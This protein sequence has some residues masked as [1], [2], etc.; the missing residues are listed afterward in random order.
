MDSIV[1]ALGAGSGIDIRAL[2]TQ[3]ATASRAPREAALARRSER[4]EARIS[5]LAQMAATIDSFSA[6]LT[7]LATGGT[8]RAQASSSDPA[9]VVATARA[10]SSGSVA[11][12]STSIE[13]LN[14]ARAQ[15]LVSAN[16]ADSAAAVGEGVLAITT[17]SGTT[18]ITVDSNNNSLTG[19]AAAI[20]ASGSG[21]RARIVSDADGTR[22]ALTGSTGAAA[23][24]EIEIVSGSGSGIERLAYASGGGGAMTLSQ[25]AADAI[26][27]IDG[28]ELRRSTNRIDDAID[29]LSLDL[30]SATVGRTVALS[31][32][33]PT[34]ALGSAIGDFVTAFNE[35]KAQLD[36]LGSGE[37]AQLRGEPAL[38][39]LRKRLSA[40]STGQL[41]SRGDGPQ[42]LAEIGVRTNRDGTLSLD[43]VRLAA[44]LDS[45]AAA[46]A[47][48]FAPEAFTD[49]AAVRIASD[50]SR[51]RPG[52]YRLTNILAAASGNPASGFIDGLAMTAA[53]NNLVAPRSS[54]VAGL[55]LTVS[56]DVAE[57]TVTIDPGLA[58]SL[59]SISDALKSASGP[60]ATSQERLRREAKAIADEEE[61]LG[62]TAARYE[63]QLLKTFAAMDSRVAGLRATQSYLTQQIAIWNNKDA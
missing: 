62:R 60:L 54:S 24:F 37:S 39:D 20:N 38:V 15:S 13:V 57:A 11:T 48:F 35:V 19:V 29:G 33:L 53:G 16:F 1:T 18:Q 50:T 10:S 9:A 26:I 22:L 44:A 12:S 59:R 61:K 4:N 45:N 30:R 40:L 31:V 51:L 43:T 6:S 47:R 58:G 41:V 25:S 3:L 55:I 23:A 32:S 56:G 27:K 21:I 7:A 49:N 5:G 8:L 34:A 17:A 52:S 14:L 42:S 46:V 2:V 28:V 36:S 63:E